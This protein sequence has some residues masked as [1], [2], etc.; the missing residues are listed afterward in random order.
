MLTKHDIQNEA[1][2]GNVTLKSQDNIKIKE[3][4]RGMR[5]VY[6]ETKQ[7]FLVILLKYNICHTSS[8]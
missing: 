1:I 2:T 3:G 5:Q 8:N 4:E 6:F 7:I